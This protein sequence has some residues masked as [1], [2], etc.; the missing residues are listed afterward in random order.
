MNTTS[1]TSLSVTVKNRARR[2][3]CL[4]L[5]EEFCRAYSDE[6][7]TFRFLPVTPAMEA[8]LA[9]H[10]EALNTQKN[11]GQPRPVWS[12]GRV[13]LMYQARFL[14]ALGKSPDR[15]WKSHTLAAWGS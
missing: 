8:W 7:S 5:P 2:A 9:R 14:M 12:K 4:P 1:A 11:Y 10:P 13:H 6:N 15:P 3:L